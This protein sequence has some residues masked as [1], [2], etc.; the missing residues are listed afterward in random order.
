MAYPIEPTEGQII[1][2]DTVFA[3]N[4][5]AR[6][7]MSDQEL[8]DGY[9]NDGEIET[10]LTSR[11]DANRFNNFLYQMHNT[12]I[13]VLKAVRE[14]I[15]DKI[16]STG[17][18]M[19]GVLNMGN[20][21]ITNLGTP[22]LDTDATTKQYVDNAMNGN[23]MW[24]SEIKMLA[25]PSIPTLPQDVEIVPCDG[26]ALSRTAYSELFSLIG[27]AFGNGDGSTTFNIPDYRGLFLR[28]WAGG[29][30]R[31][32][33]RIYGTIQQSGSPNITGK[34]GCV[35]EWEIRPAEGAF[36]YD[37]YVG[38]AGP[39]NTDSQALVSF[40]AS[41]VSNVYQNGLNEIR[42]TNSTVYYVIRIK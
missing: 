35:E 32:S 1:P 34:F 23:T 42:P 28:G 17:G 40:D 13:Y 12:L 2:L 9:N 24:I 33:G 38:Y 11:P 16:S 3:E 10:A 15:S 22:T 27:T 18:V 21:K 31:D 19:S 8:L 7:E 39:G 4:N 14:I 5:T 20:K 30:G 25:Y 37:S 29:S 6:V 36:A 26:R 41:R